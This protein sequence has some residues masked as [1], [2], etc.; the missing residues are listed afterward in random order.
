MEARGH[1][2]PGDLVAHGGQRRG[3]AGWMRALLQHQLAAVALR[4]MGQRSGRRRA[5][6]GDQ[7]RAQRDYQDYPGLSAAI[8]HDQE[9]PWSHGYGFSNMETQTP[10]TPETIYSICSISKLFTSVALMGFRDTGTVRMDDPV[11]DHL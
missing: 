11:S 8:V 10:T 6:A 2:L 4:D 9:L 1:G 7:R 3:E 5:G